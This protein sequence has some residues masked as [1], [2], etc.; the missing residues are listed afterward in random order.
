MATTNPDPDPTS[1]Q[2]RR[3][4]D[5]RDQSTLYMEEFVAS[6]DERESALTAASA[7]RDNE[8]RSLAE[9]H[10]IQDGLHKAFGRLLAVA[11]D[12]VT[13]S[14]L[15]EMTSKN[16]EIYALRS[17]L[18]TW[19]DKQAA[20][21]EAVSNLQ[22]S[23]TPLDAKQLGVGFQ[24]L[25]KRG[26]DSQAYDKAR[27]LA[28]PNK[29]ASSETRFKADAMKTF[30]TW[31]RCTKT[32][33][34]IMSVN[35]DKPQILTAIEANIMMKVKFRQAWINWSGMDTYDIEESFAYIDDDGAK[36]KDKSSDQFSL[37][38]LH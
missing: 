24:I 32:Y 23:S 34:K 16:A 1:R 26:N 6:R 22:G 19:R 2:S 28:R 15:D 36:V 12:K 17:C 13:A 25:T 33:Q 5:L 11:T 31:Y 29:F 37:V 9:K 20:A 27:Q 38:E 10:Y 18:A 4:I 21:Q 3:T 7:L 14:V 30:C 35:Y 8:A